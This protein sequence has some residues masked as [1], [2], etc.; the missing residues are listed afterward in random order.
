MSTARRAAAAVLLVCLRGPA[1]VAGGQAPLPLAP[2]AVCPPHLARLF[3]P[4]DATRDGS[5]QYL[6][7][8]SA[9]PLDELRPP[10]WSA[11]ESGAADAFAGASPEVRRAVALL[12][13]GRRLRV[14]R[15]W[16][17][18]PES[19]DSIALI[20]P[21]PSD[22]LDRIASGTLI[23]RTRIMRERGPNGGL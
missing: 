6:V 5:V 10:T 18:G 21:P 22:S 15:G 23:I 13:G 3:A 1:A 16:V 14:A 8:R 12:Y 17:E 9:R 11:G 19:L 4:A 20:A 7:C 2:D